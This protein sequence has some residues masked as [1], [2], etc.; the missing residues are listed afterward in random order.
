[1]AFELVVEL[2]EELAGSRAIPAILE[3]ARPDLSV[4]LAVDP[5]LLAI[6]L[7]PR[8]DLAEV[9]VVA[10]RE[11]TGRVV[12]GLRV[13][14]AER[15]EL[16]GPPQVDERRGG[17]DPPHLVTPGIVAEGPNVAIRAEP[18]IV[19]RPRRAPAPAGD[20]EPLEALGE[21]PQ[22]LEPERL[23]GSGDVVLAHLVAMVTL[24]E[25]RSWPRTRGSSGRSIRS[26]SGGSRSAR[27]RAGSGTTDRPGGAG[28][29]AGSRRAGP[30]GDRDHVPGRWAALDVDRD[31]ADP[32]LAV[33]RPAAGDVELRHRAAFG[34]WHE[35]HQYV[36]RGTSPGSAADRTSVPH[37]GHGRPARP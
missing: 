4:G 30:G 28:R 22:L 25:P 1:M 2:M 8:R 36:V 10:E 27:A 20:A 24:S 14:D 3:P 29:G 17:L 18:P 31:V 32:G 19:H 33:R 26:T 6:A 37:R 16:R 13:G 9:A 5:A 12:E 7:A 35:G 21:R 34:A 23:G 15:R 11:A